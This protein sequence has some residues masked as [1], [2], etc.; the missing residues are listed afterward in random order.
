MGLRYDGIFLEEMHC[1]DGGVIYDT[2]VFVNF[3]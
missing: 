3:I 2:K 1:Y